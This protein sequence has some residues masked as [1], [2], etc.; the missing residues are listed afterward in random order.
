MKENHRG[1]QA[2]NLREIEPGRV[3]KARK[4]SAAF[5]QGVAPGKV[6]PF[7]APQRKSSFSVD[8]P[9]ERTRVQ[10]LKARVQSRQYRISSL[11]LAGKMI[12]ESLL[13]DLSCQKRGAPK[14]E[15]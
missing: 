5:S 10:E 2:A 3:M 7:A 8:I 9:W 6:L 15:R 13:E 4:A 12:R 11:R 14:A 1:Y